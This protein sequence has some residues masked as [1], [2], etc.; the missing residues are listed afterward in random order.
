MTIAFC[1][2]PRCSMHDPAEPA[3][4]FYF[5]IGFHHPKVAGRIQ[6]YRCKHCGITFSDRTFSIDYYTKK[7]IN[8]L[9]LFERTPYE[10]LFG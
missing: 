4:D 7:S 8:Y 1:P 5:R 10:E 9:E 2:N 3:H 6:R